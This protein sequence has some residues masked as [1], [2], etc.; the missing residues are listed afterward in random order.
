MLIFRPEGLHRPPVSG[1][2]LARQTKTVA[3]VRCSHPGQAGH[4]QIDRTFG[5]GGTRDLVRRGRADKRIAPRAN[6]ADR[7]WVA[8][9][10][11]VNPTLT[12]FGEA[13]EVFIDR[14]SADGVQRETPSPWCA[15]V[16]G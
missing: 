7:R 3:V 11:A 10:Q 6:A 9:V 5:R 1:R 8:S 14:G 12:E 4:L 2:T 16:T 15:R 13:N